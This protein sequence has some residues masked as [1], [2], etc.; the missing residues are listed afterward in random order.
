MNIVIHSRP[1]TQLILQQHKGF[2][3]HRCRKML[4]TSKN[5]NATTK[6]W[7]WGRER[8]RETSKNARENTVIGL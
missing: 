5:A 7:E 3:R 6:D 1:S 2:I 4:Q 8:E